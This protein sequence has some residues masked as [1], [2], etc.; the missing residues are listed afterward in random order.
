MMKIF[1]RSYVEFSIYEFF[2][3][4]FGSAIFSTAYIIALELVVA[5]HRTVVG[6]LLNCF[7][8]FGNIY[9]GVMA[10]IFKNYKLVLLFCYAPAFVIITYI[11]LQPRSEFIFREI[12]IYHYLS[13]SMCALFTGIRWLLSKGRRQEAKQI[14]IKAAELNKTQ[15]SESIL[16]KLDDVNLQ[17]K[18]DDDE[19]VNQNEQQTKSRKTIFM[20]LLLMSYLWFSTIFVYYGLNINS[21]YLEFW[22]KYVNF[23]VSHNIDKKKPSSDHKNQ[24]PQSSNCE[25]VVFRLSSP[26]SCLRISSQSH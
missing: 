21:V 26:L 13:F 1:A 7:Y 17:L 11:W 15:L 18:S 3:A 10:M 2:D 4:F 8:A 9:L 19:E 23:I 6:I 25:N 14:L 24:F 5:K 22:N 20:Q 16:T 12:L